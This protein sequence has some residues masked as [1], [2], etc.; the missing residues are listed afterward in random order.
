MRRD[1]I[2]FLRRWIGVFF[3]RDIIFIVIGRNKERIDKE[4]IDSGYF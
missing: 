3:I 4:W 1:N 2:R